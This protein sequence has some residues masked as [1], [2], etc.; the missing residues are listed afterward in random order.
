MEVTRKLF[1]V[2]S[3][4]NEPR[5]FCFIVA[6]Q[7]N[8]E[9]KSWFCHVTRIDSGTMQKGARCYFNEEPN[10]RGAIAINVD[11]RD[12][13][14]KFEQSALQALSGRRDPGGAV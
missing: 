12:V 7:P 13:V 9:K 10:E 5:G 4:V 3:Y 1:G 2:I 8:G 14:P 11:I 6:R